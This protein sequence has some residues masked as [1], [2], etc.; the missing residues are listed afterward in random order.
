MVEHANIPQHVNSVSSGSGM[1]RIVR[2]GHDLTF[3]DVLKTQLERDTG[4]SFSAHAMERMN[5]RDMTLGSEEMT[6][7]SDA[8]S[9]AEEKGAVDSLILLNELAF[10]VSIRNRTVVTAMS[11]DTVK[12]NVFTNIDSAVIG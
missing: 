10:I 2:T 5:E 3:S 11:G 9:R 8:V 6:R 12:S 1:T 4:I 7:L